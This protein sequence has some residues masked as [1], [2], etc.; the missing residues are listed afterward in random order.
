M[1]LLRAI[2]QFGLSLFVALLVATSVAGGY[3]LFTCRDGVARTS[4][5]CPHRERTVPSG[6]ELRALCCSVEHYQIERAPSDTPRPRLEAVAMASAV[7]GWSSVDLAAWAGVVPKVERLPRP[8]AG[9]PILLQK[10]SFLI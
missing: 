5:C 6:A 10:Q 9:P 3:S 8:G 4:C 7:P 2:T 1:R